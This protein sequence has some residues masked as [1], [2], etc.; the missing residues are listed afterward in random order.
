[1]L[2]EATKRSMTADP[3]IRRPSRI[4]ARSVYVRAFAY[5]ELV[6]MEQAQS[7]SRWCW[8]CRL[9]RSCALAKKWAARDRRKGAKD[10]LAGLDAV[11]YLLN[12][13][14]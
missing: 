2:R 1:M 7:T 9:K 5:I 10:S 14:Q 12:A 11:F 6:D 3:G 13:M 8:I 4:C